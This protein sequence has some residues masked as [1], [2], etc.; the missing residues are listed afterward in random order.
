MKIQKFLLLAASCPLFF[1]ATHAVAGNAA[2]SGGFSN[3]KIQ[4]I[5][6]K[7]D[8]QEPSY[9]VTRMGASMWFQTQFDNVQS[10]VQ[11]QVSGYGTKTLEVK[12]NGLLAKAVSDDALTEGG[13]LTFDLQDSGTLQA[14]DKLHLMQ[15]TTLALTVAANTMLV[16]TGEYSYRDTIDPVLGYAANAVV[17]AYFGPYGGLGNAWRTEQTDTFTRRFTIGY[18]NNT[19]VDSYTYLGFDSEVYLDGPSVATVVSS[20]PEPAHGAMLALGLGLVCCASRRRR[21]LH[22]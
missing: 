5:D 10:F 15:S 11:E 20:V 4:I 7:T 14:G 8:A 6:L 17:K 16:V 9:T 1:G 12:H 18:I 21:N 13:T 3:V 2:I 22:A 19:S